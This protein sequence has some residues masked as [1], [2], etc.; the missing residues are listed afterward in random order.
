MTPTVAY[1]GIAGAFG[2]EAC[3][4]FLPHCDRVA[5]AS[6]AEVA[7]AV[8][9]GAT[10][11]GMLPIENSIAGPVPGVAE[12]IEEQ[13]LVIRRRLSLA[14]R[15]HL[16]ARPGTRLRSIERVVSH[17]MALAQCA[18]RLSAAAIMPTS[19]PN[20]AVA[21]REVAE[22]KDPG[23]AAIASA[24]AAELYGLAILCSDVQDRADNITTFALVAR[25]C[26]HEA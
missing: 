17:P 14:V 18:A 10:E 9:A 24:A 25:D 16:M 22:S 26:G 6:F 20:T 15:L 21:A 2:E 13:A 12:L 19:A 4:A 7:G 3:R 1:Q 8:R 5:K 23:I 11:F